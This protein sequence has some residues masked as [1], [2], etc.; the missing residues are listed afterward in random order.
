M[1]YLFVA[2]ILTLIF[3]FSPK[4]LNQEPRK[5]RVTLE[6]SLQDWQSIITSIQSSDAL[7]A[8]GASA[9]AMSIITQLQPQIAQANKEDS[10]NQ[11]KNKK[12]AKKP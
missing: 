9:V 12:E 3:A 10:L 7:S 4:K 8:K 11:A 2:T 6:Y 1:K 5:F